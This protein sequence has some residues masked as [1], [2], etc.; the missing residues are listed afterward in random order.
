VNIVDKIRYRDKRYGDFLWFGNTWEN[1]G[2]NAFPNPSRYV[3]ICYRYFLWRN[4][5]EKGKNKRIVSFGKKVT[6]SYRLPTYLP[7][8][9]TINKYKRKRYLRT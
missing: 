6:M 9:P 8:I 2:K 5:A 1:V 4:L 7:T 3:T